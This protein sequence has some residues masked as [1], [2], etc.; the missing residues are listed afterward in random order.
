MADERPTRP[1]RQSI[2]EVRQRANAITAARR[3][4]RLEATR[5]VS[6]EEAR[7][8]DLSPEAQDKF[9]N[10]RIARGQAPLSPVKPKSDPYIAPPQQLRPL[11]PNDLETVIAARNFLGLDEDPGK[12]WKGI[13]PGSSSESALKLAQYEAPEGSKA[14]TKWKYLLI[15]DLIRTRLSGPKAR[16]FRRTVTWAINKLMDVRTELAKK[17]IDLGKTDRTIWNA[18]KDDTVKRVVTTPRIRVAWLA[19]WRGPPAP[20]KAE[21]RQKI[22]GT[23]DCSFVGRG[24]RTDGEA[25]LKE[26]DPGV[27]HCLACGW[28]RQL[29]DRE[30]PRFYDQFKKTDAGIVELA[31]WRGLDEAT[32]VT[33]TQVSPLQ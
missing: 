11:N 8:R 15:A 22:I 28:T 1:S 32:V 9:N 24:E 30:I 2:E 23:H 7:W 29:I 3:A 12:D 19:N 6:Y 5:G 13:A 27:V 26:N 16:K 25:V 33:E 21:M 14:Y 4:E 17:G 20:R 18:W 31:R 10:L